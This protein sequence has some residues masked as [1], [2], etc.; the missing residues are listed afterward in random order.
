M[1]LLPE[2]PP[3]GR[4]HHTTTV[5]TAG[6][7]HG[8]NQTNPLRTVQPGG[9]FVQPYAAAT[10]VRPGSKPCV[11]TATLLLGCCFLYANKT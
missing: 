9:M 7:L 1:I 4:C 2:H 3:L 6:T 8:R 11:G 5:T 10:V